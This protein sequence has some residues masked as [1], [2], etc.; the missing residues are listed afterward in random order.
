[1]RKLIDDFLDSCIG[2]TTAEIAA[3]S[4]TNLLLRCIGIFIEEGLCGDDETWCAEPALL[5]IILDECCLHRTQLVA[6]HQ[7]FGGDDRLVLRLDGQDGAGVNGLVVHEYSAGA[8]SAAIADTLRSGDLELL[9]QRI[10]QRD[11]RLQL[12]GV[13]LAVH[14]ELDVALART[15]DFYVLAFDFEDGWSDYKRS[16]CGD[17]G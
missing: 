1:M 16:R 3:E 2:A 4:V 11:P 17:A 15:M 7:A 6:L 13:L 14:S 9:T 5:R 12:R 8:A 10:E